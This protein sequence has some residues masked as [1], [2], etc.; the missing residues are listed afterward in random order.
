[1]VDLGRAELL[2]YGGGHT[3]SDALLWVPAAGVLLAADLVV[4]DSHAWVGD[5]DV[6]SWRRI[7]TEL[8]EL[9]PAIVVPGHGPVG[10]GDDIA[11]MDAYLEELVGLEPGAPMPPEL[12]DLAHPEV[13]ARNLTAL[14][15]R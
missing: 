13:F 7:L 8:E 15:S 10:T 6:P 5:G 1:M 11:L 2:T 9:D 4:V 12:A 14:R 3:E